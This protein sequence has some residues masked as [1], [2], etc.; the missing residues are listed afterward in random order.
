MIRRGL[1]GSNALNMSDKL[2]RSD[3]VIL[4]ITSC[5]SAV[6]LKLESSEHLGLQYNNVT[7]EHGRHCNWS[8]KLLRGCSERHQI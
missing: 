4:F 3:A 8:G 5:F 7:G 1:E 2:H 6:Y